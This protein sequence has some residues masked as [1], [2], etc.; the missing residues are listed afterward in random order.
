MERKWVGYLVLGLSLSLSACSAGTTT[1][2]P[3]VS[4]DSTKVA[5][6]PNSEDVQEEATDS[7][8][9]PQA[10][11]IKSGDEMGSRSNPLPI[12]AT[13]V[14]DDEMG[15]VWEV[16]L[17][18]PSLN[19]N[20]LV[21]AENMFNDEPPE[22]LQYAL[23]PVS[24]TYLGDETGTAAWDLEFAFVSSSGTT[25]KQFDVMAVGPNELSNINELY[26]GGV[27]EGNIVIA[28]PSVDAESGTWRVGTSWGSAEAF[29]SAQ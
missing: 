15:G 8:V 16:T 13:V 24:A 9:D 21:L 10:E 23:L 27:A 4:L 26:D 7:G 1:I 20:E 18:P 5:S 28:I 17:L 2:T 22:G 3:T 29:F 19:A 25:H 11:S 6:E 14:L 12:G